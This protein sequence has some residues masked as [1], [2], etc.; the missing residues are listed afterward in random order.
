MIQIDGFQVKLPTGAWGPLR[1]QITVNNGTILTVVGPSGSGKT[2]LCLMLC[3]LADDSL[4][5]GVV[6]FD[7]R[8]HSTISDFDRAKQLAYVPSDPTLLFS[9][10]KRTVEGELALAWQLIGEVPT[11]ENGLLR[12]LVDA[13]DLSTLLDRDPFTLS[14]GESARTAIAIAAA[15]LPRVIAIDQAY[16][17]L[18]VSAIKS[19]RIALS[20]FL[21]LD[22]I[23]VETF[24][25]SPPWLALYEDK[26][27]EQNPPAKRSSDWKLFVRDASAIINDTRPLNFGTLPHQIFTVLRPKEL[28]DINAAIFDAQGMRFEYP[29][30]CFKLG[31]IDLQLSGGDRVAIVGPNGIGKTTL[32]KCLALL[33]EP[34]FGSM[35][36]THADGSVSVPQVKNLHQWAGSVLYVFQNPDDQLYLSTVRRELN[37]TAIRL[38]RSNADLSLKIALALGLELFLDRS[39]F[40]LP[41]PY[42]RLVCLASALAAET[43]VLLLDEPTAGLDENQIDALVGALDMFRPTGSALAFVS[44]DS[45][46]VSR[47]A[48]CTIELA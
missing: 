48:T 35:R 3:A 20:R 34:A 24:S 18:D 45:D 26:G 27:D 28:T 5:K 15:K 7:G 21:P 10:T 31:P 33:L 43:P 47:V 44:H 30:S 6:T 23:I 32:L 14:G 13:F 11:L 8:A 36:A 4:A 19:I 37:E 16:D 29:N 9:G 1:E 39:P 40:D 42:R 41:R 46:F 12:R 2:A 22:S 38:H 25:R 17:N